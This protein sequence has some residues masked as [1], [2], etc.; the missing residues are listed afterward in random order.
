V[1][2]SI[3][4][5]DFFRILNAI[6]EGEEG[7]EKELEE[8]IKQYKNANDSK[9]FL[10]ELGKIF[11]QLGIVELYKYTGSKDLKAISI[12]GKEAWDELAEKNEEQLPRHLANT[13]I[14]NAKDNKLQNTLSKKWEVRP[15]EVN[16][17][18]KPMAQY[19]TE[20]IIEF[21]E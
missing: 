21:L 13:M 18:I 8:K 4:F 12:L 6:K 2:E 17:H 16:K 7:K 20:G 3:E 11:I 1:S 15:R 14:E 19:I 9:S 10:D 5:S